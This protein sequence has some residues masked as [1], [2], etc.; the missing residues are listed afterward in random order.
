MSRRLCGYAALASL[1]VGLFGL[2]AH[3]RDSAPDPLPNSSLGP[4][5]V[6]ILEGGVGLQRPLNRN[7]SLL[8]AG[9]PWSMAGWLRTSRRQGGEIIV[10]AVGV[11][12]RGNWRGIALSDG[13]L[14]LVA[15]PSS[16]HTNTA[17]ASNRWYAVAAVYD[18]S[19][20]RIFLDGRQL[21]TAP[22]ATIRVEPVLELAPVSPLG[23]HFGGSLAQ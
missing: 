9:A 21:A 8:D 1:C 2:S 22:A 23:A 6:D 19:L 13:T 15:G 4:F 3:S 7:A 11:P 20:A 18:G 5:N 14:T 17:L 10:S 16:L 12:S